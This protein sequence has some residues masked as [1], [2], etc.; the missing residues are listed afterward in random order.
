[1]LLACFSMSYSQVGAEETSTAAEVNATAEVQTEAKTPKPSTKPI[2][3]LRELIDSRKDVKTEARKE[4][5]A[6]QAEKREEVK[7]VMEEKK[8]DLKDLRGKMA[9]STLE[10]KARVEAARL[11]IA[12]STEAR[13]DMRETKAKERIDNRFSKMTERFEATIER[14]EA[15]KVKISAR[16][17][18]MNAEGKDTVAASDFVVQAD[19][20]LKKAAEALVALEEAV[21]SVLDTG[22][23]VDENTTARPD[24]SASRNAAQEIEKNLREAHKALEKSVASLKGLSPIKNASSTRAN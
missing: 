20:Y 4:V 21:Q 23:G 10:T 19:L 17:D 15:I 2:Q 1:M 3:K 9:S 16:I 7:K 12:S 22:T 24:L 13:K 8:E 18:K 5:K 6:I 11:K 14:E